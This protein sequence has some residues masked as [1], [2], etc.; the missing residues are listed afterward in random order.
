VKSN[1]LR[2]TTHLAIAEDLLRYGNITKSTLDQA[3]VTRT[4]TNI[5]VGIANIGAMSPSSIGYLSGA[6]NVQPMVA[7]TQ[8]ASLQSDGTLPYEVSGLCVTVAGVAV[9]VFY[10]SPTNVRFFLPADISEGM[11]EVIVSSQDGYICEGLVSVERSVSR[12]MTTNDDDNGS[13]AIVNGQNLIAT[14]FDVTSPGNFNSDKRTRL[15]FFASG[16]SGSVVNGATV[17]DITV[18][19]KVRVNLA[20]AIT[21]EARLP[22]GQV[23]TLP[24]EFAGAQGAV[25][26]LD[27]VT[28]ILRSELKGAGIV[29]LTLVVNGRRSSSPTV[30]IK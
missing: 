19:G 2:V 20:E 11:A 1:L 27:Q 26:G 15:T 28:V 5:V 24:V 3:T 30:F 21:V 7:Q 17:N 8:T 10:A 12:I 18:N 14:N 29:Q 16:I 6:G 25:P 23:L 22:N 9:P 4:R 13:I